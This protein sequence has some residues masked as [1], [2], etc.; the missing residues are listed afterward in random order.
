M[1]IQLAT[2]F[3]LRQR[4]ADLSQPPLV[5]Q[6]ITLAD[7]ALVEIAGFSGKFKQVWRAKSCARVPLAPRC[8]TERAADIAVVVG[9]RVSAGVDPELPVVRFPRQLAG[10]QLI[11]ND[12]D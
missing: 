4:V 2:Q 11:R 6:P 10:V 5:I 1:S 9:D 7:P 8:R 12:S 3:K